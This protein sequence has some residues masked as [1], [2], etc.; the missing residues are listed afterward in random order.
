MTLAIVQ[1]IKNNITLSKLDKKALQI[2]LKAMFKNRH[3]SICD[4]NKLCDL[5][6][7][8]PNPDS[9]KALSALHCVHWTDMCSE[10]QQLV[11][12]S[13]LETFQNPTF[14]LTRIDNIPILR[15]N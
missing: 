13:V 5:A 12:D 11:F 7:V 1:V 9:Y 3:F 6:N 15:D 2:G 10:V 8:V 4:Y 14:D